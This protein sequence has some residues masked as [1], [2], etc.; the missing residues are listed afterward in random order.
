MTDLG[1]I[2]RQMEHDP[3]AAATILGEAAVAAA[4]AA[5]A[6][7]TSSSNDDSSVAA[8]QEKV[9]KSSKGVTMGIR[10]YAHCQPWRTSTPGGPHHPPVVL[11][12]ATRRVYSA[13]TYI[14]ND[15]CTC[16]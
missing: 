14:Q 10:H 7:S 6:A 2:M 1:L 11:N 5:L 13:R 9:R 16:M 15:G 4:D 12:A 3:A 8:L